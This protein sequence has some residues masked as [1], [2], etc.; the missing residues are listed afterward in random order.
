MEENVYDRREIEEDYRQ[1]GQ[2]EHEEVLRLYAKL[3]QKNSE[4]LT[5]DLRKFPITEES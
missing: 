5:G 4:I 3:I 1:W 2:G